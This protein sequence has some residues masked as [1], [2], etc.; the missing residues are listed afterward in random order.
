M[1]RSPLKRG[2]FSL[3]RTPIAA[4]SKKRAK[5][6]RERTEVLRPLREAQTW[7]ARCGKTGLELNGHEL[8]GRAQ[9]GSIVDPENIIL[10]CNPCN[11]WCED[12]PAEA[13]AQGWK[14]RRWAA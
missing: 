10:L 2:S 9:G 1:K 7:C 11:V 5:L 8:L 6:N 4:V 3:R 12:N 13:V 14:R